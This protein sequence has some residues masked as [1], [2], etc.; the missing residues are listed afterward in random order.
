M[1]QALELLWLAKSMSQNEG[2]KACLRMKQC[3]SGQSVSPVSQSVSPSV[4]RLVS[5][6]SQ[7]K[8]VENSNK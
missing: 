5:Q 2:K 1:M 6:S 4:C 7:V 8:S 3:Q